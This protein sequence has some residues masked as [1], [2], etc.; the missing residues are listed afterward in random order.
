MKFLKQIAKPSV[1]LGASLV[2]AA[3]LHRR[4]A[5]AVPFLVG[6]P[7]AIVIS[8]IL[9]KLIDEPRPPGPKF[10]EG[11]SFPS[12]HA[13]ALS[14]Y[15]TMLARWSQRWWAL[16]LTGA[17]IAAI[18]V[19]RVR[20]HEHWPHDVVAGDL[21]GAS[22]ALLGELAGHAVGSPERG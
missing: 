16:P 14:A 3:A 6:V 8:K 18:D 12:G 7:L 5:E 13:C 4:R 19:S 11:E 2:T 15:A 10:G 17:L 21:L 9:K 20:E 1:V 22:C